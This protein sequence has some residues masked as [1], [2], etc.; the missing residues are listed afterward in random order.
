[1]TIG[2]QWGLHTE[3]HSNTTKWVSEPHRPNVANRLN[4]DAHCSSCGECEGLTQLQPRDL[5][6]Q[7]PPQNGRIRLL[8]E[9]H[10][11][12]VDDRPVTLRVL[13]TIGHVASQIMAYEQS[14]GSHPVSLYTEQAAVR[15]EVETERTRAEN[16]NNK[17]RMHDVKKQ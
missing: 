13:V 12:V 15:D 11:S 6:K 16:L 5:D 8:R 2:R 14:V 3:M 9:R 10:R 17:G 7:H 1:M 4:V